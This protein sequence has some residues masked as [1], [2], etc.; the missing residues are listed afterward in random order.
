MEE[1]A[2]LAQLPNNDLA[3]HLPGLQP[4][5]AAALKRFAE[6]NSA[7]TLWS[8]GAD[9]FLS[10]FLQGDGWVPAVHEELKAMSEPSCGSNKN[11]VA[12][13]RRS[14]A[15]YARVALLA[16][17]I[18]SLPRSPFSS[19]DAS[20]AQAYFKAY[21]A[22]QGERTGVALRR[23]NRSLAKSSS[24]SVFEPVARLQLF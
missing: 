20:A 21:L 7:D 13:I 23:T 10:N 3:E 18:V 24:P 14:Q 22:A 4:L 16:K 9:A 1:D 12:L 11:S 15:A 8:V 17:V 19:T 5:S 6:L 2:E